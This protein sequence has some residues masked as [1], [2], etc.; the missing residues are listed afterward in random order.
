M[1][2]RLYIATTTVET[3]RRDVMRK[4]GIHSVPD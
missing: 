4:L 1:G 3:H 2:K